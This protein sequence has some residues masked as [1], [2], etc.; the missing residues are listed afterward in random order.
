MLVIIVIMVLTFVFHARTDLTVLSSHFV[1]A[2]MYGR[3]NEW[4]TKLYLGEQQIDQNVW[5]HK[6]GII[7]NAFILVIS[8]N[9]NINLVLPF[10]ASRRPMRCNWSLIGVLLHVG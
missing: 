9:Y 5:E 6:I 4:V 2:S 10:S 8:L 7:F 3:S 1:L